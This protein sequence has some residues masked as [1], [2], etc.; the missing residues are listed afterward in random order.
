LCYV[1]AIRS[2][3][4]P[5]LYVGITY[6]VKERVGRHNDG[7]ERTTKGYR[8]FELVWTE[9]FNTRAEAR[10]REIYLK[11]GS[12]KEFLGRKISKIKDKRP[13]GEIGRPACR[14]AGALASGGQAPCG[15]YTLFEA[16]FVHIFMLGLPTTLKTG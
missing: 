3:T 4:R 16:W 8:P 10:R 1:Y 6:N 13:D 2:L 7:R 15:M 9:A 11:S 14:Q 12:G 5:Y